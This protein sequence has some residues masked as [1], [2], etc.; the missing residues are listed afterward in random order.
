MAHKTAGGPGRLVS[1]GSKEAGGQAFEANRA[2]L[3]ELFKAAYEGDLSRLEQLLLDFS[4][5]ET[6]HSS[7]LRQASSSPPSASSLSPSSP[8]SGASASAFVESLSPEAR[9]VFASTLAEFR[10]GRRRSALHFACAGGCRDVASLLL[11]LSPSLLDLRD[12]AEETPLLLLLKATA[13][14][15][16]GEKKREGLLDLLQ[17]LLDRGA[18]VN[19]KNLDGVTPLHVAAGAEDE[20]EAREILSRLLNAGAKVDAVCA[21]FGTPLQHAILSGRRAN[22]QFLL[23][24]GANPDGEAKGDSVQCALPPPLVFASSAG[25]AETVEMLLRAG[26]NPS[27]TDGEGWTALQ[28]AAEAG[29][30]AGV[31]ALLAAGADAN[32][33]TQGATAFDLALRYGHL[34]TAALLKEAME[35]EDVPRRE[36]SA[37]DTQVP[38]SPDAA[39]EGRSE[40]GKNAHETNSAGAAFA[41]EYE[42]EEKPAELSEDQKT[43]GEEAEAKK[44]QANELVAQSKY[45]EALDVYLAAL[46]IC[47]RIQQTRHQRAV[48]HANSC[49]MLLNLKQTPKKALEHAE[50]AIA[51]DPEWVRGYY[52]A[53]Q[54]LVALGDH[55]EAAQLYWQALMRDPGNKDISREFR[56]T[57]ETAKTMHQRTAN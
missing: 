32:V 4:S 24:N 57:V 23:D 18:D 47:P 42:V 29:S 15:P 55:A 53:G 16:S 33:V 9:K 39:S 30:E 6:G 13:S 34:A 14:T 45:Q 56:A 46:Q 19:A 3:A 27:R 38:Q 1:P 22:A 51:L 37:P 52:R 26:A 21:T 54:A 43:K 25:H 20:T 28:C 31:R 7:K 11:L 41:G 10:D 49:L 17:L 44:K 12:E 2:Q 48:L 35:R 36:R 5:S 40:R 8:S 50:R